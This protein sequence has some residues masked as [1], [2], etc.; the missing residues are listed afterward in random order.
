MAVQ[1]GPPADLLRGLHSKFAEL[2]AEMDAEAS[3]M[4]ANSS[5]PSKAERS[6]DA[7]QGLP[8]KAVRTLHSTAPGWQSQMP[9][10]VSKPDPLSPGICSATS[11]SCSRL[12]LYR[13]YALRFGGL[14]S[15]AGTKDCWLARWSALPAQLQGHAD[16]A[17]ISKNLAVFILLALLAAALV[18]L[19]AASWP[20]LCLRASAQMHSDGLW[21]VLKAPLDLA[22]AS[23]PGQLLSR[24]AKDDLDVLD[25]RLPSLLAQALACV[26]A[27]FSA[28]MA[29]LFSSP[30]LAP[31]A[32]LLALLMWRLAAAYSPVAAD[33]ARMVSVLNGPV[34]AHLLECLEGRE[35]LRT[36]GQQGKAVTHALW[37]LEASAR[38]QILNMGLQ[39]WFALQL[40]LIGGAMLLCVSVMIVLQTDAHLGMSGLSLTY[41]LTLTAL[42]KYLVNYSTRASAQM[43][44]CAPLRSDARQMADETL[45]APGASGKEAPESGA[46]GAGDATSQ[47]KATAL[48]MLKS[49][50]SMAA[51]PQDLFGAIVPEAFH[52]ICSGVLKE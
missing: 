25:A 37:V 35:Y 39:R 24:F 17:T 12:K 32:G 33:C 40:E 28:L 20:L 29:I 46:S 41:A 18:T 43:A 3:T 47:I 2:L 50:R 48:N 27:L 21:K 34:V 26:A 14:I 15:C 31:M 23:V 1:C 11:A 5:G 44:S 4:V 19:Q 9:V 16:G 38:A 36:F 10:A 7:M 22:I 6:S 13:G 30:G 8:L 52:S 51:S 49:A 45:A 42:A